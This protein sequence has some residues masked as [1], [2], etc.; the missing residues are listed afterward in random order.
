MD[1]AHMHHEQAEPAGDRWTTM[2]HG[3]AFLVA[4]Y[5][6]GPSGDRDFESVNHLMVVAG[7]GLWGGRVSL[8]GTFTIEP[9]TVPPEGS[10]LLFQRG[11]TYK[12]VLLIDRQHAHDLF[13]QLAAAWDRRLSSAVA[14][15]GYAGILGEPPVG[16]PAYT[17]RLSASALPSAPL[18][19]H[20]LDSTHLS[21]DVISAGFTFG[22]FTLEGGVFHGRE[23]GENRFDIDGGKID[24]YAGRLSLNPIEG[25]T[26]QVS[27]C[28]REHPE[29]IEEG[30]QTR[31]TA[32]VSYEH[33]LS[34][35]EVGATLAYGRNLLP[36]D[37]V[38]RGAL[39]EG[40]WTF[41]EHDTVSARLESVDRD[42]YE[43]INKTARPDTVAP[44]TTRIDAITLS[45]LHDL[46]GLGPLGAS[47][48]IAATTSH[49]DSILDAT[50]GKNPLSGQLFLRLTYPASHGTGGH[51]HH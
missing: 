15:R 44:D 11:E 38:E 19:H 50:Y 18:S 5:Q 7:H 22:V 48:G 46:P 26:L 40:L 16:P 43:L 2:I 32:S 28:R 1:H 8:L 6:D 4:N 33:A 21:A 9:I 25:L 51:H 20:N 31:Q 47:A 35:G 3:Y 23:P 34:G 24:S 49:Y 41:H 13:I 37:L 12:G 10:P 42:V 30:N 27:A 17:H 36:D 14:F 45:Y 39:L 29:A